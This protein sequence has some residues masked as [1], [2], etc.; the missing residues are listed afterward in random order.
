MR[1]LK[2]IVKDITPPI[3]VK[4]LRKVVPRAPAE[5]PVPQSEPAPAK[6]VTMFSG[7]YQSFAEAAAHCEGYDAKGPAESAANQLRR[8]LQAPQPAEIDGRFQQV[9]SALC[10]AR[11]HLRKTSLSVLDIGGASGGYFF[12]MRTLLPATQLR[13]HVIETPTLAAA[14][15][16]VAGDLLTF[17]HD[18]PADQTFDVA[19]ISGTL[20][21]LPDPLA[22]LRRAAQ[23]AEWIVLTR[24]PTHSERA[25]FM[26]QTVPAHI[27]QGSMPIHIFSRAELAEAIAE[28]GT[29]ELSWSVTLDDPAFVG[30]D[31]SN[32]G[33]LIRSARKTAAAG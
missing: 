31:I 25:Q 9:H 14:C 23:Q 15:T 19:L 27:H 30:M 24:V 12:R 16:A 4:G 33:Y 10:I 8:L 6:P 28:V 7:D 17:G 22:S 13:W 21:Y 2:Q 18:I 26:V 3:L 1:M 29:V 11:D 32:V 20:Q 5:P